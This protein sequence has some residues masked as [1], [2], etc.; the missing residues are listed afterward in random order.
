MREIKFR[1]WDEINKEMVYE[2]EPKSFF[3]YVL[4]SYDILKKFE[5]VMQFTGLND[6]TGKE[7]YEGDIVKT[8]YGHYAIEWNDDCCK[9]QFTNGMDINDG[10]M[11]GM[12]KLIIGNIYEN[13]NLIT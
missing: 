10:E 8:A 2:T 7:I 1:A 4:F 5:T 11:Y 9:W 6:E 13:K 3:G 12:T